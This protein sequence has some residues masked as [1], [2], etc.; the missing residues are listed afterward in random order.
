MVHLSLQYHIVCGAP[1]PDLPCEI[2][3]L[4][5][6]VIVGGHSQAN[7]CC[8]RRVNSLTSQVDMTDI[9][10]LMAVTSPANVRWKPFPSVMNRDILRGA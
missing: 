6:V 7:T 5:Y 8:Q 9:M 2:N 1:F 3:Y 10:H 4:I